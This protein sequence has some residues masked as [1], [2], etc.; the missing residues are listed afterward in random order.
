MERLIPDP[1]FAGDTGDADSALAAEL[2]AYARHESSH[3]DVLL[4]LQDCAAAGPGGRDAGG[5]GVRRTR[6]R[7][8]Q[9]Q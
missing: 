5:G 6:T 4:A 2:A 8:R 1:G 3:G 9:D 7:P